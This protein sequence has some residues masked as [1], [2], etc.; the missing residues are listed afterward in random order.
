MRRYIN[1]MP[2]FKYEI[3]RTVKYVTGPM[4]IEAETWLDARAILQKSFRQN[5]AYKNAEIVRI[6]NEG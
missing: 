2:I 3:H 4:L 1:K 5:H 6:K